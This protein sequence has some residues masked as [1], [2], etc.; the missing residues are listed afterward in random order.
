M[1]T[2]S[3]RRFSAGDMDAYRPMRL[4]ALQKECGMFGNSYEQEA[5]FTDAQWLERL[6]NTNKA[7][8]GLYSG[9]E[10]IGITGITSD[11]Y[12]PGLAYMTQSYIRKQYRGR[13]L[14]G[15]LYEA[16]L[17]WAKEHNIKQLIIGHRKN[18]LA[19]KHANQRYGFVYTHS[20]PRTW[21]DNATED[22][23]YYKL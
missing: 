15:L 10:L 7:C 5:A 13:G 8:F 4:E 23:L 19:S 1:A 3:I 18:N 21:P 20:E 6:T 17:Q 22:M 9:N 11:G 16:R 12:A 2:Y 14:S